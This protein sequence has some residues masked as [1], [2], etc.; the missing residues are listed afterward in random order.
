MNARF[1][2]ASALFATFALLGV[3]LATFTSP[4]SATGPEC[5][6]AC[7][8]R[9]G[10]PPATATGANELGLQFHSDTPGW[11][12]GVCFWEAPTETGNHTASLWDSSGTRLGT[13]TSVVAGTAGLENCVDF[14]PLV[15]IAAN[16]TYTASYTSNTAF[17][18]YPSQFLHEA[19][20]LPPLHAGAFAG[21]M[22][23]PGTFPTASSGGDGYGVDVAFIDTQIGITNDCTS[24]LT[25]PTTPSSAPGNASATVSWG[26]AQS[27]PPGCI[28]GYE[29]TPF[30]NGVAQSA[31][32]IPGLGTTTVISGLTNGQAYTFTIAAESGRSVG[33]ASTST[34][35]VTVGAPTAPT[36][37]KVTRVST[38]A[39]KVSFKASHN[40]GAVI[41]KYTATCTSP[42]GPAESKSGTSSPLIIAGL[43]NAR[44]YACAVR[45]TNRRGNGP[46]S[47]RSAEVKA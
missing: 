9:I 35:P 23:S 15:P 7:S 34:G 20:D 29:V 21:A 32:L 26:P 25:A 3:T 43:S 6:T 24:T 14:N 38:H 22:G 8:F 39:V 16:A 19:V 30:L 11:I 44:A 47:V 42:A 28:A 41:T 5:E 40:N 45:A 17:D 13:A 33:P 46:W 10:H 37:L 31:T 12:A 36:A 1:R 18:V 4:A 27:T 2:T